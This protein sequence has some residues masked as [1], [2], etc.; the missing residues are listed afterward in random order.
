MTA[1]II[2]T[3]YGV[4]LKFFM[5]ALVLVLLLAIYLLIKKQ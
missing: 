5:A 1:W 3:L 2:F 4:A